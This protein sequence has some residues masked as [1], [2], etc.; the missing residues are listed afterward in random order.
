MQEYLMAGYL[1]LAAK[2]RPPSERSSTKSCTLLKYL[3]SII[4]L[5]SVLFVFPLGFVVVSPPLTVS[6]L[7]SNAATSS[8]PLPP[9][10]AVFVA[11]ADVRATAVS[12]MR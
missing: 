4:C 1:P 12:G 3:P 11:D 6:L 10:A 2:S 9:K 7:L 8:R 5:S